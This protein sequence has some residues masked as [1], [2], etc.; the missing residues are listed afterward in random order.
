MN[1]TCLQGVRKYGKNFK[2]IADVI[3]NKTESHVR[4]FFVN[5]R[6]RYNLD[7][8][9]A[10]YERENGCQQELAMDT[11]PEKVCS[12]F[13]HLSQAKINDP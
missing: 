2:A 8:V 5:Y 10:E 11:E 6:R 7:E 3:S 4:S 9:F 1:S 12:C 13:L